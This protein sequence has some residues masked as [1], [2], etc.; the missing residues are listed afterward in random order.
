[1]DGLHLH[2]A[3]GPKVRKKK[4]CA[5]LKRA[6]HVKAGYCIEKAPVSNGSR[7]AEIP[8]FAS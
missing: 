3:F 2:S 7:T 8:G 6:M 1:M 5:K 4:N